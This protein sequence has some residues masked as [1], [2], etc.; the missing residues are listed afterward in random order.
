MR[1]GVF[2]AL[3]GDQDLDT[4]LDYVQKIGL[5]TVEVGTGNYPPDTHC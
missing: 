3:F 4:T 5:D 1:L 2:L